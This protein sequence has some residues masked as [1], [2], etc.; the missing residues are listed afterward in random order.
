MRVDFLNAGA[1]AGS[2][3]KTTDPLKNGNKKAN[4]AK[5]YSTGKTMGTSE[6]SLDEVNQAVDQLNKTMKTYYTE[7]HFEIHE[8][9]GEIM[10]K[11]INRDDGT[12]IREIPPEKIL[13]MVAYFKKVLGI[14]VDEL[15]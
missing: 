10:V 15:I 13:N 5:E 3:V 1:V 14:I 6:I 9:S 7:L 4:S 12:L 11:M 8:K 2:A